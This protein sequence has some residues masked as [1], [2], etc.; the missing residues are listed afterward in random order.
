MSI[1]NF[2]FEHIDVNF[3]KVKKPYLDFYNEFNKQVVNYAYKK[4]RV[5]LL[6]LTYFSILEL[7]SQIISESKPDESC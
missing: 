2:H 6:K 3:F 7:A 1:S 5:V 4:N